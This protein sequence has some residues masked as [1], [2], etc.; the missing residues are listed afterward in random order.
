M[1]IAMNKEKIIKDIN[2]GVPFDQ[3]RFSPYRDDIDVA[4]A[5][6][7]KNGL[8][9]QFLSKRLQDN[10]HIVVK[11]FI[12]NKYALNYASERLHNDIKLIWGMLDMNPSGLEFCKHHIKNNI[13]YQQP[14]SII[15][16][17]FHFKFFTFVIV[18]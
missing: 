2:N 5:L 18:S 10:E 9:L 12:Q 13:N 16:G 17:C 14:K 11:A 6:V 1:L 7:S 4:I 15:D 8:D 3:L